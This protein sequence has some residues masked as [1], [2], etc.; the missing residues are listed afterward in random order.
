MCQALKYLHGKSVIHRDIKPENLLNCLGTIKIAD[1]GWSIHAP[2]HKRQTLC[3]TLDYLPP[4]MV[5]DMPH[6]YRV[7][8]WSLG[9]LCYEF[10]VGYPPFEAEDN[11]QTY[12]RIKH[13]DLR[14]PGHVSNEARDLIMRVL[15]YE[16]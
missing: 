13:I 7:D 4:E 8:I 9:I 16:P 11:Q 15:C 10:L 1:F 3:G 6:D 12:N 14:F 5:D 2:E